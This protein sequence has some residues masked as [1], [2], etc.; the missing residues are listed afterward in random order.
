MKNLTEIKRWATLRCERCGH[1]FRWSRDARHSFGNRDGKV[2]HRPCLEAVMWQSK[3]DERLVILDL[4]TDIA[5]LN[6][7]TIE[8]VIENRTER[9]SDA[10]T[11]LSNR[12]WRVFRDLGK[13][14]AE[15]R[16]EQNRHE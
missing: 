1:R 16:E 3:A 7:L 11:T 12:S 6:H 15:N 14:R 8:G 4:V 5:G 2:Y 13:Y 9:M 10:R